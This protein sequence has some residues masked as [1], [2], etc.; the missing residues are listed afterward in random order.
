[1]RAGLGKEAVDEKSCEIRAEIVPKGVFISFQILEDT[2]DTYL[3]NR[4]S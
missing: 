3:T 2:G 4:D 1:M